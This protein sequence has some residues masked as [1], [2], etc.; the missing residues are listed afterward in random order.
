MFLWPEL[1][2]NSRVIGLSDPNSNQEL[3][4]LTADYLQAQPI[5]W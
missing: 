3:G 2:K 1:I 5:V 4:D